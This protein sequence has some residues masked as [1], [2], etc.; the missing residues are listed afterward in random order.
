MNMPSS[1]HNEIPS[2]TF[3]LKQATD[4]LSSVPLTV[5]KTE[6]GFDVTFRDLLLN[7]NNPDS[8]TASITLNKH[9]VNMQEGRD[10]GCFCV[11]VDK[12]TEKMKNIAAKAEG[13]TNIP[14]A[15]R[16]KAVMD[17][18]LSNVQ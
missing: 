16:A 7:K 6:N 13:F 10:F 12:P 11:T 4:A 1:G 5:E 18:L 14:E 15:E 9:P 3:H 2:D 8:P 17:L